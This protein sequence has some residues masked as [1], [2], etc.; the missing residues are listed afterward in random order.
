MSTKEPW[1]TLSLSL[2]PT[3]LIRSRPTSRQPSC[4]STSFSVAITW[5]AEYH[6]GD[7]AG[8]RCNKGALFN[9]RQ[10]F[11]ST[12]TCNRLA[13]SPSQF[14]TQ[15]H[16]RHASCCLVGW[17]GW[18]YPKPNPR[19]DNLRWHAPQAA[20]VHIQFKQRKG[21]QPGVTHLL[22]SCLHVYACD[23]AVHVQ[24]GLLGSRLLVFPFPSEGLACA[25][26]CSQ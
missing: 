25:S 13:N 17:R 1:C 7:C 9:E 24:P 22:D 26:D 2:P 15:P 8:A 12:N 20:A 21:A 14:T 5:G 3:R 23:H 6:N 16:A 18:E 11:G 19:S 4:C 10:L